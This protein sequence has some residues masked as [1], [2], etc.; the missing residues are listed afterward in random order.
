MR[1]SRCHDARETRANSSDGFAECSGDLPLA[2][3]GEVEEDGCG[4][5][6]DDHDCGDD[7]DG[8]DGAFR[9][10]DGAGVSAGAADVVVAL[11]GG[12]VADPAGGDVFGVAV[13]GER[14]RRHEEREDQQDEVVDRRHHVFR[15]DNGSEESSK[16]LWLPLTGELGCFGTTKSFAV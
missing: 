16:T 8:D 12:V 15:V 10:G 1:G 2:L 3:F 4:D 6:A 9:E 7:G 5:A 14:Q 13:L 11:C